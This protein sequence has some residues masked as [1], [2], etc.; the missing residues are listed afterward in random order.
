MVNSTNDG[1]ISNSQISDLG[2]VVV[3]LTEIWIRTKC[4]IGIE[5]GDEFKNKFSDGPC[6]HHHAVF[7]Q[8]LRYRSLELLER[9]ELVIW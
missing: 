6:D 4:W 9:P 2:D 1:H 3:S 8:A 5:E 7:Q